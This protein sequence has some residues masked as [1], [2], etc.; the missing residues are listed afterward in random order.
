MFKHV[1]VQE[2]KIQWTF[3]IGIPSPCLLGSH[4]TRQYNMCIL[5]TISTFLFFSSALREI[6]CIVNECTAFYLFLC[7]LCVLYVMVAVF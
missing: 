7:C 3:L 1:D 2:L 4:F 5:S 6:T